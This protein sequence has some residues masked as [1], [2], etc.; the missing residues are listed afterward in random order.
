MHN[1]DGNKIIHFSYEVSSKI[2]TLIF[3]EFV[4]LPMF[5]EL[6]STSGVRN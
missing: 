4:V 3:K 5:E 2:D 6:W 1:R